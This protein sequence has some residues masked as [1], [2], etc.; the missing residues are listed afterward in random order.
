MPALPKDLA[1]Q[2][3]GPSAS[4]SPAPTARSEK[5][6]G[7]PLCVLIVEDSAE[8]TAL[9]VRALKRGGYDP[10]VK[11]VE[12]AEE[13]ERELRD[14][15]WEAII[16]DYRLPRFSAPDALRVSQSRRLDVP[17]IVV[18]GTI[19]E[20]AAVELMRSGAHDY[21]MKGNLSR[22][23]MAIERE[24]KQA[25]GRRER[26][27]AEE[28]LALHTQELARANAE[29]EQFVHVASHDLKEPLRMVV[30][31]TDLFVKRYRGQLGA[32]ADEIITLAAEGA[33]R[34]YRL[35]DDVLAFSQVGK[36][37]EE[38]RTTDA[39]APFSRA[40]G[41]LDRAIRESGAEIS[42]GPLPMLLAAP[43]L[44]VLLF[45]NL[46]D[47]AIKFRSEAPPRIEVQAERLGDQWCFS[48]RDNGIG[49]DVQHRER[50]F[51]IFQR[52]HHREK[53]AGNGM[54]LTICKRIVEIHGGRIWIEAAED[55]G[56]IVFFTLAAALP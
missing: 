32:E 48:V 24:I 23:P 16:S 46:L 44:L 7:R 39:N 10:I 18:S 26:R 25:E 21:V 47:N 35:I 42:H 2:S 3:F 9:T 49:I 11:R 34:M 55:Q 38:M 19:G 28:A 50:V 51:V 53:Y 30:N 40:V 12:T 56:S 6:P 36:S 29:L 22:L 1:T 14:P 8:D 15:C 43:S 20:E 37:S 17:F 13:M 33:T 31:F 45:E 52:L 54:G 4:E 27:R 41:N 5:S